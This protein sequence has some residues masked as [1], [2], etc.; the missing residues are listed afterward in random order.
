MAPRVR[1]L[2]IEL[3]TLSLHFYCWNFGGDMAGCARQVVQP[4]FQLVL[5]LPFSKAARLL[6]PEVALA[7]WLRT[8]PHPGGLKCGALAYSSGRLFSESFVV[9][10]LS[11]DL[12]EFDLIFG[13]L[14][15]LVAL[16]L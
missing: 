15:F 4:R 13:S 10:V 12:V 6:G 14:N 8:W 7:C 11:M 16:E 5:T 3:S 2:L 9:W 1:S